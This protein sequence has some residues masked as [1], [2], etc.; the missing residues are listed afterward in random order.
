MKLFRRKTRNENLGAVRIVKR[1]QLEPEVSEGD[2]RSFF[3]KFDERERNVPVA[4]IAEWKQMTVENL[5]ILPMMA[6]AASISTLSSMCPMTTVSIDVPVLQSVSFRT[7]GV[8][9]FTKACSI[10]RPGHSRS[11]RR[12]GTRRLKAM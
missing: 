4:M 1:V 3:A 7:T 9:Y 5:S 8:E 11:E 10:S 12:S 6:C 2:I